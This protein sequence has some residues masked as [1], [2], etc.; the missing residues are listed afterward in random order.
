L[1]AAAQAAADIKT[2]SGELLPWGG[3][4]VEF[5]LIS[6]SLWAKYAGT[7]EKRRHAA[8]ELDGDK[9]AFQID[10]SKFE[11]VGQ[12]TDANVDGYYVRVYSPPMI[13]YEK[14]RAL[15]Q[16]I[17][18]YPLVTHPRPRPR[19]FVDIYSVLEKRRS[20]VIQQADLIPQV[21]A[22][23]EVPLNFLSRITNSEQ[24]AFHERAWTQ[25]QQQLPNARAFEFY[26]E[27]VAEFIRELESLGIFQSPT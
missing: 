20:D 18:D 12:T 15:C 27:P 23:K 3:W 13:V 2:V 8:L 16:Q 6:L 10:I 26:F 21:F 9:K 11:F 24:R 25:V 19:D 17:P 4:A 14:L 1:N 7:P 5:K 22:A